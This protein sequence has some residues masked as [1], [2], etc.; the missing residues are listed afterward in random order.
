[1]HRFAAAAAMAAVLLI[2]PLR[3]AAQPSP[4]LPLP[5]KGR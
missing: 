2:S 4:P 3:A 1:M 5:V